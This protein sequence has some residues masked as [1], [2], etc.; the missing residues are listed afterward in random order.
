MDLYN[1][2]RQ[3]PIFLIFEILQRQIFLIIENLNLNSL[4]L[5]FNNLIDIY[6]KLYIQKLDEKKNNI[7]NNEISEESNFNLL[8]SESNDDKISDFSDFSD[9]NDIFDI[10]DFDSGI[11]NDIFI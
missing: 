9:D 1:L 4:I 10:S 5:Y 7:S 2:R 8:D 6:G 11:I 3:S